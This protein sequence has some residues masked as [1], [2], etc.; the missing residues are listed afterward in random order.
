MA[1]DTS[2]SAMNKSRP[3]YTKTVIRN[4]AWSISVMVGLYLLFNIFSLLILEFQLELHLDKQID[5]EIEHFLNTF[6]IDGDS[7]V[8]TNPAEFEE[9]DLVE[10][11]ENPFFLQIYT[12]SGEIL[13]RSK[14]LASYAALPLHFPESSETTSFGNL[15]LD[16]QALRVGYH[17]ITNIQQED[18]G[19][20]QLATPKNTAKYIANR[21]ILFNV[22]TFPLV[23]TLIISFSIILAR[24]SF[25][26]INRIIDLANKISAT[27]L[28][29]RLS[30][31]ADP[32]DELGRLRD[33]LNSL[34]DRLEQQIARISNFTDDASHQL[35]SPLTV[36]NSEID[37]LLKQR[38]GNAENQKT[39]EI[40]HEQTQRMIQIVRTLLIMAKVRHDPGV[41]RSVFNLSRMIEDDIK[42]LYAGENVSYEIAKDIHLR[43]DKDYFAI[44]IQNLINNALK[45]SQAG[46]PVHVSAARKNNHV[47]IEVMDQGM[48]IPDEEKQLIFGRFYRGTA[49][50]NMGVKGYGLGLSFVHSIIESMGGTVKVEDNQP[51]GSRFVITLAALQLR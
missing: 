44:V 32:H 37:L 9:S 17:R 14:N 34:F 20:L 31:E 3:L 29:A 49:G 7:L 1:K 22:L 50:Q 40:M 8:I 27:N 13:V 38:P 23:L 48:G 30:Y 26:P 12:H 42:M 51:R 25:A 28:S 19:Y 41:T 21:L 45:Y 39:L 24:K 33:T 10:I 36:L 6:Y 43:G 4:A 16:D 35:M 15:S 2:S 5:H 46:A 11:T 47:R 18:V